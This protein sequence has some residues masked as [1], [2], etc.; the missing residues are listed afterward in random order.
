[1]S[2]LGRPLDES[3]ETRPFRGGKHRPVNTQFSETLATH[4]FGE[5]GIQA[6]A[7]HDEGRE[8]GDLPPAVFLEQPRCDGLR[9]LR[10]DARAA[11]RAILYAQLDV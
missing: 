3:V 9:R 6:L 4:R 5:R 10:L 8:Q 1:M 2:N 7:R 11:G